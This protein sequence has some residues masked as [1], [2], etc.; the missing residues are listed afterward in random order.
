MATITPV[1]EGAIV[2]NGIPIVDP[3]LGV[4]AVPLIDAVR[5][6]MHDLRVPLIDAV[7]ATMHDLRRLCGVMTRARLPV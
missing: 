7:R 4:D 6:T 5:A 3:K 1:V 2:V